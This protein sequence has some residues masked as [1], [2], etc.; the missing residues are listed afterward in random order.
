MIKTLGGE[1]QYEDTE[2]LTNLRRRL[3]AGRARAGG[4]SVSDA[5]AIASE[6]LRNDVALGV[7]QGFELLVSDPKIMDNF[8]ARGY[9]SLAERSQ[10][11]AHSWIGKRLLTFC[12][13]AITG[14]CLVWLLRSG[15]GIK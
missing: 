8:W 14:F 1:R 13:I 9:E 3:A 10:R 12:V 2:D 7:V 15:G 4:A 5:E 6:A 11:D